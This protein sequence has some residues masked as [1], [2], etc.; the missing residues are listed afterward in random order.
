[1]MLAKN[2]NDWPNPFPGRTYYQ[3]A[4]PDCSSSAFIFIL[5]YYIFCCIGACW[6]LA[7]IVS[8][9]PS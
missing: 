2:H 6:T 1:V 8:S 9:V 3:E 4:K 5:S 7:F